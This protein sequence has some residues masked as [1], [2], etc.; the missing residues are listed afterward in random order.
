MG[1]VMLRQRV[2]VL[3][4][5]KAAVHLCGLR[6]NGDVLCHQCLWQVGY[7]KRSCTQHHS[8]TGHPFNHK[9]KIKSQFQFTSH[10]CTHGR[11]IHI[12]LQSK[13]RN[14]FQ[15]I[16]LPSSEKITAIEVKT[17]HYWQPWLSNC[18]WW[19]VDTLMLHALQWVCHRNIQGMEAVKGSNVFS[20]LSGQENHQINAENNCQLVVTQQFVKAAEKLFKLV[21]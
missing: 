3:L 19:A 8:G 17:C 7:G 2:I 20:S 18:L 9:G 12:Y 16:Q 5:A 15:S 21:S 1:R 14:L 6:N 4:S 13:C 10:T 11:W